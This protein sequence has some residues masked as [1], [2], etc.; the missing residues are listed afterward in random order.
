M[1]LWYGVLECKGAASH[2]HLRLRPSC[3][4][5]RTHTLTQHAQASLKS[6]VRCGE[7]SN[8]SHQ[9]LA[10]TFSDPD[11]EDSVWETD[12]PAV[13]PLFAEAAERCPRLRSLALGRQGESVPDTSLSEQASRLSALTSL[14]LHGTPLA[15]VKA[16]AGATALRRLSL[17]DCAPNGV[18]HDA[19]GWRH[20][21][22]ALT[23]LHTLQVRCDQQLGFQNVVLLSLAVPTLQQQWTHKSVF[24]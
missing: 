20:P 13:E 6:M 22:A 23:N 16:L 15:D 5:R 11:E 14:A 24:A 12:P 10:L 19:E 8:P 18:G 21:L 9:D 2:N 17:V 4:S 1:L 3:T 7:A